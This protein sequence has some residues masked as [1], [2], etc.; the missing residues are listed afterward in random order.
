MRTLGEKGVMGNDEKHFGRPT[1]MVFLPDGTFFVSD[2]YVNTRVVKFDKNCNFL[3][4][5]GSK[6]TAP[7]QFNLV[8]GVALDANRR[9]YVLDRS[10]HRIQI[11]DENGTFLDQWPNLRSPTTIEITKDQFAWVGDSATNRMPKY[12][13]N[14]KLLTYWGV[15]GKDDL[16]FDDPHQFS[17]DSEGNLYIA[18][19]YNFTVKKFVPKAGA[20]ASRMVGQPFVFPEKGAR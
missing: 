11:F 8:H 4:A 18:D 7:G 3:M 17:V 1:E 16:G 13:L 9:L 6:G 12:D 14:G 20:D 10:N 5:W 15:G 19:V 2:G